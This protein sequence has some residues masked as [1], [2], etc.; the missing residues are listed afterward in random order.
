MDFDDTRVLLAAV[1]RAVKPTTTLIDTFFPNMQTFNTEVVDMEYREGGRAMA[2]FVVPGTK[3][4]NMA[5]NG[6]T[7][8]SYKAPLM[9]PKRTIEPA[10]ILMRGFGETVYSTKTPEERAAEIRARDLNELVD[11][12][13][14]RQEWM[15]AQLLLNG[16]YSIEGYADDGKAQKVD[17]ISFPGFKNKKTLSG[18]DTWD[19]STASIYDDIAEVSQKISR[20]A[21]E[22]P[23]VAIC[24]NTVEKYLLNNEQIL[25]YLMIPS[26]DNM[27]LMSIQPQLIRPDLRRIGFISALNLELYAYD[28]GYLDADGNFVPYIPDDNIIIGVKGKGRRLFGAVTQLEGDGN[29]HTYA[30]QYVPKVT[31]DVESDVTSLTLSSRCVICPDFLDSWATIKVK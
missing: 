16:S 22:I 1:E 29:Y 6:S 26:R 20:A 19:N 23:T 13:V 10:D 18:T 3:G 27:A 14:R 7:I 5:R 15:A 21:G 17:T 8:R 28:G 25:K 4:V 9:K 24:S 2:P 30:S 31:A 12:C 11:M